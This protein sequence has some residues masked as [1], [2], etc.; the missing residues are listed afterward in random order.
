MNF[1]NTV[2]NTDFTNITIVKWE[3]NIISYFTISNDI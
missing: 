3:D 2:L 1:K